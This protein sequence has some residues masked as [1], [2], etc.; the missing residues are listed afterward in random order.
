[1]QVPRLAF[2]ELNPLLSFSSF[3]LEALHLETHSSDRQR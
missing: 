3:L 2:S 1:M